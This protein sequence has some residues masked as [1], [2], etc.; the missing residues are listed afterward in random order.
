MRQA[1]VPR[2]AHRE[3]APE[4]RLLRYL[5]GEG[6]LECLAARPRASVHDR[7]VARVASWG[8]PPSSACAQAFARSGL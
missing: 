8:R 4:G 1:T 3:D 5:A 2:F 6:P 7:A